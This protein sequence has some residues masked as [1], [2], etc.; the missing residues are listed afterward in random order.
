MT[1]HDWLT[2]FLATT[3]ACVVYD[4]LGAVSRALVRRIRGL[5]RWIP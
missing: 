4:V 1:F 3:T 5:V 2:V